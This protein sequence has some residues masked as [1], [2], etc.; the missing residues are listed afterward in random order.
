MMHLAIY[1]YLALSLF[2]C[3]TATAGPAEQPTAATERPRSRQQVVADLGAVLKS[4]ALS[5]SVNGLH[6]VLQSGNDETVVFSSGATRPLVPA[7][8]VKLFTTTLAL[9]AL[10][11]DYQFPTELFATP[12]EAGVING[13]LIIRGY[14]DPWLLPERLWYL[15]SQLS[16]RGVRTITGDIVVDDSYFAGP[17]SA[18]GL[19]QDDSSSAYMAESAAVAVGFNAIAVHLRIGT[20]HQPSGE[21]KTVEIVIEPPVSNIKIR[22][23]VVVGAVGT[24]TRLSIDVSPDAHGIGSTLT[25]NGTL[26]IVDGSYTTWRRIHNPAFHAGNAFKTLLG[27]VGIRVLGKIRR[28]AHTDLAAYPHHQD[29]GGC[30]P[31]ARAATQAK[32]D[33]HSNAASPPENQPKP[34]LTTWSPPLG[35]LVAKVNKYSNNFMAAQLIRAVAARC[36]GA[37]GTWTNGKRALEEFLRQELGMPSTAYEINNA[38]GLHDVNRVSPAQVV[39]LM[40]YASSQPDYDVEFLNSLAVGGR[41]GTLSDRLN[42]P[43]LSGRIRGKTGSLAVASALNGVVRSRGGNRLLFSFITNGYKRGLAAVQEAQDLVVRIL[44][45]QDESLAASK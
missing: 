28:I 45:S 10:G 3:A 14:G 23:Q 9:H 22:N 4:P 34:L 40:T 25:T 8:T 43:W 6:V 24:P 42:Q 44:A 18:N 38:S 13:D 33:A 21:S 26:S 15:A 30:G 1:S 39:D 37:P 31:V 7:S 41:V 11:P 17:S 32:Q 29:N 5:G 19:E 36:F 16:Y 2:A 35:E 27:Q 12:P 20:T